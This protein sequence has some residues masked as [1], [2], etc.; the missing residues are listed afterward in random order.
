MKAWI[1]E[2]LAEKGRFEI[3]V[4]GESDG[5]DREQAV[6]KVQP[7]IEAGA[8]WWIEAKWGA[9]DQAD[10]EQVVLERAR[11]GPPR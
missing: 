2:N 5:L 7:W 1:T 9:L 11:K 8:T 10:G 3:V 6:K 4:E